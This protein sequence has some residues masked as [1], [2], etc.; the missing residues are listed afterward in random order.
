VLLTVRRLGGATVDAVARSLGVTVSGARQHLSAL[1]DDGLVSTTEI[2]R[3]PG[4]RGR[5]R[6]RYHVTDRGDALFPKGY[7]TL[8]TELL[9]YLA[10]DADGTVDRLFDRRLRD[11]TTA[12]LDQLAPLRALDD[13][14]RALAHLLD[15]EG[16]LA[17]VEETDDGYLLVEHNCAIAAV[18]RRYH[19]ACTTE[20]ALVAAVLGDVT[21]ER[22]EHLVAGDH[23][24][25]YWIRPALPPA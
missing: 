8:T 24:C 20:L 13:R 5:R 9:G 15:E 7:A 6:L 22:V 18:A 1:V 25:A 12:T 4:E 19:Q 2:P 3:G 11:R 10:D 23:R 16:Y 17:A 21:V 14:V